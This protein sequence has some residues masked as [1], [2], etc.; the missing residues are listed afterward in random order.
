MN[1]RELSKDIPNLTATVHSVRHTYYSMSRRADCNDSV[2]A[3]IGH[4]KKKG[5]RVAQS[6]G[7]FVDDVLL[8]E[9]QKVWTFIENLLG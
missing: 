4:A 9:S 6:Y 3:I 2:I 8:R 7:L 1:A 5:S